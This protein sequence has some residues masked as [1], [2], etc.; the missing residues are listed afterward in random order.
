M[1]ILHRHVKSFLFIGLGTVPMQDPV[2][3]AQEAKRCVTELGLAGIPIG[4]HVGEKN[5]DHES[6][7]SVSSM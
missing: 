6:F 4:S 3:A 7:T 5:L 1:M 2:L